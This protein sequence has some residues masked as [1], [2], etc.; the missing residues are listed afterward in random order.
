MTD[1]EVSQSRPNKPRIF[2]GYIVAAVAIVVMLLGTG[3]RTSFGVFFKPMI[4]DFGWSRGGMS[5]AVTLSMLVQGV[6]GIFMG[7]L[8]DK[9]GPRLIITLC[10]FLT[11]LGFLLASTVSSFWQIYLYYG[12][13]VGLG[14]GGVFVVLVSTV[15]RWFFKRR[16]TMT[17]IVLSGMGMSALV[18]APLANWLIAAFSWQLAFVILGSSVMVIGIGLSQFLK[19]DPSK[20]GMLPFGKTEK[21]ERIVTTNTEGLVLKEAI[22]TWHFWTAIPIFLCLGYCMFSIMV[23]IVPHITDTGTSAT[24]AANILA[25]SGGMQVVGGIVWGGMV[26]KI[27]NKRVLI[28]CFASLA[29]ASYLLIPYSYQWVF[30]VVALLFGVGIGGGVVT[31]SGLIAD[32]FGMKSHGLILGIISFSFTIGSAIGPLITGHIFD[33]DGSYQTAFLICAALS[34]AGLILT[35]ILKPTRRSV[36]RG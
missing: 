35:A 36:P 10:C 32:L 2:Y 13:I 24:A 22:R 7:R 4:E 1:N 31:E 20:I 23:H 12:L 14:M 21:E 33:I 6:W 9:F 28:L 18:M 16:G 26:D 27:G 8:N 11:G 15:S 3:T 29:A 19:R 25:F 30:Y 34:I 5:A 17:G